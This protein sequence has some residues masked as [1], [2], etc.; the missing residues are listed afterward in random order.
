MSKVAIERHSNFRMHKL[1]YLSIAI[2]AILLIVAIR[3]FLPHGHVA[4]PPT[5]LLLIH[6]LLE[7]FIIFLSFSLFATA[8]LTTSIE[9]RN[10]NFFLGLLFFAIGTFDLLHTIFYKGMPFAEGEFSGNRATWFW[11]VARLTESVGVGIVVTFPLKVI[12]R[13]RSIGL[14]TAL[15]SVGFISSI[16]ILRQDWLPV[17]LDDENGMT[18]MKVFLEY[19]ICA[20]I[21][22]VLIAL[23]LEYRKSKKLDV[24]RLGLAIFFIMTGELF[25]TH[26]V[27]ID[28]VENL[29]GHIYKFVGYMYLFRALFYLQVQDILT[30]KKQAERKWREAENMLFEAEKNLSKLVLQAHEEERKRVSREL[31]DGIGQSL[32]SILMTLNIAELEVSEE[33]AP[34][35]QNVK[36]MTVEAMQEV[37]DIAHSLRPSSLDDFGFLTALRIY[38]S[39]FEKVHNIQVALRTSG[40]MKRMDPEIETALYRICQEALT[41]CAK[42]ANPKLI[43]ITLDHNPYEILLTIRDNGKGFTIEDYMK[44]TVGKH[45]GIGIFSMKERAETCGGTFEI[46]SK[47]E[48]GTTVRIIIPK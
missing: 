28:D 9:S 48:E 38:R 34:C 19:V 45:R 46:T 44:R 43:E 39:Q 18:K 2:I 8:L 16:V 26:Y 40:G 12:T 17:F 5:Q 27:Q 4:I 13:H 29:L 41:N 47:V 25:I 6:T 22:V 21:F 15:I 11:V 3:I 33:Q 10:A 30:D 24:L 23:L 1:R 35:L 42:Y 32:Y 31:H 36:R 14:V 20:I 37:R 7:S